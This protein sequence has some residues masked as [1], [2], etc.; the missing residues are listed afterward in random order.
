MA[1]STPEAHACEWSCRAFVCLMSGLLL[2]GCSSSASPRGA[3]AHGRATTTSAPTSTTD[4]PTSTSGTR[5]VFA[6]GTF[7]ATDRSLTDRV[8]SAGLAGGMIRIVAADGGV[9]HED[10]VGSVTGTTPLDVASSSKWLTAATLMTF[11]DQGDIGLDDDIARWLPEF[12]GSDPPITVRE[13]LDHT[14]GVHD[15]A[16]QSDGTPLAACVS[17]LAASPREFPAG[18]NFSYG[19]SPF[20]VVGRLIEVLGGADFATVVHQ[21]LT[22]PLGMDAATWPGAPAAANPAFGLRV[23]VDD[24]GR[25]LAMILDDGMANGARVLSA[26]A[27]HQ[28]VSDQV[29]AYDTSHDYSVGITQIPRYGLGCWPDVVDPSG[30]TTVVSGNGGEGF[31]PWV[32]F[33]TRTWGI[34]GVQDDRGAQLAVPASQA[35]EVSARAGHL[36]P[37]PPAREDVIVRPQNPSLTTQRLE[38]LSDGVIA[39]AS[40]LLVLDIGR[41]HVHGDG[42]LF[43]EILQRWP[44]YVAYIVSFTV[45][46]LIWVAHHSM[47]ERISSVDRPLLF[48]NLA[49][50]LGIGFIPWPTSVL[51]DYIRDGGINASVATALYSLTMTLI[52]IV[53]MG[54]WLHLVRHPE[55]TTEA[56]TE[57]QL[58]RSLRLAAVSPIVY[59]IT[60]GLAFV[61]PYLCLVVYAMLAVY[62][63]RGPS[64]R[65][66]LAGQAEMAETAETDTPEL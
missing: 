63:A 10:A 29:S 45:I 19:N 54:M 61:S 50:L 60:I 8:M 7:D 6:P 17:V 58:R 3:R 37:S 21:R 66:L 34:V 55:H 9:I 27:V 42:G 11:V 5:T 46:G 48:L 13:L 44:A 49:L 47:F 1:R 28:M 15:N 32:D 4:A 57:A 33:T 2:I 52:G 26:A 59:G 38:G 56:V 39:I 25:F 16:C 30:K 12:A 40:T 22:G 64:A 35:V 14:S 18:S 23:T 51:A 36:T 65:A 31:Y 62:F 24:Y 43:D 20:L 53:F 41:L